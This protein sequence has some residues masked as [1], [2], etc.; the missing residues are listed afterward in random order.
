MEYNTLSSIKKAIDSKKISS[1]EITEH[2]LNKIKKYNPKINAFITVLEDEALKK[3]KKIDNQLSK[4][5]I[6]NLSGIPIAQKIF[7][8]PKALK[9]H[10]VRR[11]LR[12]L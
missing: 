1:C 6:K 9:P 2:Y 3:A 7:S 8:A 10:A 11:C 12:I 4:G 5:D